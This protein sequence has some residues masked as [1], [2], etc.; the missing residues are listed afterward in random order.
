MKID[1]AFIFAS[2][3]R[4]RNSALLLPPW[5]VQGLG[6]L[7][8]ILKYFLAFGPIWY[9][10]KIEIRKLSF[11]WNLSVR[12]YQIFNLKKRNLSCSTILPP[13]GLV[14][15]DQTFTLFNMKAVWCSDN[16]WTQSVS[17]HGGYFKICL[18]S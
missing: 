5:Y 3:F 8:Q 6:T 12:T 16:S 13:L 10:M 9:S 11:G 7:G 14:E 1:L 2:F 18:D 17:I 15:G 4:N